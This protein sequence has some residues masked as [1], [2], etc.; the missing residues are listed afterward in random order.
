MDFYA[1]AGIPFAFTIELPDLGQF[2]YLLPEHQISQVSY[3]IES[4]HIKELK[5]SLLEGC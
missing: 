4:R 2:G 5:F 3:C 1:D